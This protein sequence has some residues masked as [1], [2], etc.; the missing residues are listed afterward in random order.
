MTF[1]RPFYIILNR[2]RF[3]HMGI[4]F[5]SGLRICNRIYLHLKGNN[6]IIIGDNF[7]VSSGSGYNPLARNIRAAIEM[8]KGS[9]MIIGDNVGISSS[10]IWVFDSLT[11]GNN[12]KIGGDTII[13]DSDAHSLDYLQRRNPIT[14]RPNAI[15][16][17]II[18]GSDV[19]VGT[20]CII[21]K[22]VTIGDRAIIGSGS[23]ITKDIPPDCIAAGNPCHVI[24][25]IK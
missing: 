10:C 2:I 19:L 23:V 6:T 17:G 12:T 4:K 1:S 22:G 7:G 14:D 25:Y 11:I 20:R 9:K 5:G 8:E 21:L 3:H 13:L 24:K 15:K 16:K 18:I